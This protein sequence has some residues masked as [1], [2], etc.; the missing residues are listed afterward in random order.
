MY[1]E[2]FGLS[3]AP[4]KITPN[5]SYFF[6]GASRGA[7]L[8]ALLYAIRQGEGIVKVVGEVGAGK[9]MLCR[10]L[11]EQ[12]P[13]HVDIVYLA[14]PSLT[15][16]EVL[17]AIADELH[18][19]LGADRH[20]AR[21][22]VLQQ[23]L[24]ERFAAGRQVVI[25]IDEAHAMPLESLEEV[26][27]LS[28]LE[29][30]D[31]KL[32][33]IVLFGQPELEQVLGRADMR[34]L[35]ERITHSFSLPPLHRPDVG[36]YLM[37]RLRAAG[38]RGP[39]L[40][41][42]AATR[43]LARA[44]RGLTRRVN[45][46]ADKALLAAFAANHYQVGYL[47]VSAAVRDSGYQRGKRWPWLMGLLLIGGLAVLLGRAR[48][49]SAPPAAVQRAP[50][51]AKIVPSV[52]PLT[53]QNGIDISSR[54]QAGKLWLQRQES[55]TV[56][57]QL[58]VLPV[59]QAAAMDVFLAEVARTLPVDDIRLVSSNGASAHWCMLYG[60][61]VSRHEALAALQRLPAA[62][63]RYGPV[64]R[65]AAGLREESVPAAS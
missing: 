30:A 17:L 63:K 33:Q 62:L 37:F 34:Q 59:S 4:F 24:I 64:F 26:R 31:H 43:Q 28:N 52:A 16:E 54:A 38:Y 46:L 48:Q 2:H 12:L 61:F 10:K 42:P 50:V 14:N 25:L 9:T 39:H 18:L 1:L 45:I 44:S 41:T 19:D 29:T 35:R 20:S 22:R 5:T 56:T 32:L 57:I 55:G 36:D 11:M 13:S 27:L 15:R 6:A 49:A 53:A 58:L 7:V 65:T 3:E 51:A 40:F 8:D 23:V 60:T 47:E 21:I